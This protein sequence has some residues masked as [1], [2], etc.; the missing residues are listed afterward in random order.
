MI[1]RKRDKE[2]EKEKREKTKRKEEEERKIKEGQAELLSEAG[3]DRQKP[4]ELIKRV[5][6]HEGSVQQV[7]VLPILWRLFQK[8][9]QF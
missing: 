8:A 4:P 9:R 7:S 1:A 5:Q 2:R 6:E 3:V